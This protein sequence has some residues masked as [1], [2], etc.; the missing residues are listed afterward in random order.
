MRRIA[1]LALGLGCGVA[2]RPL[3]PGSVELESPLPND[4]SK[5]AWVLCPR[6]RDA[7]PSGATVAARHR[8]CALV[9]T[10]GIEPELHRDPE[11][12]LGRASDLHKVDAG[13]LLAALVR[14]DVLHLVV[15][16]DEAPPDGEYHH[17]SHRE[18]GCT[19]RGMPFDYDC[20]RASIPKLLAHEH[21]TSIEVWNRFW[22]RWK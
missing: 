1:A 9:V 13:L 19:V 17:P 20:P 16:H 10:E 12:R 22:V 15:R 5:T 14:W 3:K 8:G 21:V 18:A 11:M 6:G 2:A 4:A 7:L